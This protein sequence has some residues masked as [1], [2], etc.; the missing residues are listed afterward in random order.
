MKKYI[1]LVIFLFSLIILSGCVSNKPE[2]FLSNEPT[3]A[4]DII[5]EVSSQTLSPWTNNNYFF[6]VFKSVGADKS[7]VLG[8]F[9]TK[10]VGDKKFKEYIIPGPPEIQLNLDICG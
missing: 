4:N 1:Q 9:G 10:C 2:N 8:P 6:E 7:Q 3:I 5:T